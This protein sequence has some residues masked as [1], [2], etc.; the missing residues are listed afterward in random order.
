TNGTSYYADN[1][2]LAVDAALGQQINDPVD[3]HLSDQLFIHGNTD[4]TTTV[5]VNVV[6]ANGANL[7]G[8]P[9]VRIDGPTD[10]GTHFNLDGP[11]SGGFFIWDIRF[12]DANNWYELY[13]VT[14][15][16]SD[17]PVLGAGAFEFP[18]GFAAT[19]DIWFQ[20]MGTALHR[21]ADLRSL[22]Q[23]VSVTPV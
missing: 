21:Q 13:T 2:H 19:Q 11:V 23:G 9:V 18:A 12:D 5:H 10:A 8:I 20:T 17:E 7:D 3:D 14:A 15:N 6:A 16:G 4:G 22:L 1:G